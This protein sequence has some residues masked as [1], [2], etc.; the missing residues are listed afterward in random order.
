MHHRRDNIANKEM[1]T[2][3][4][5][6]PCMKL[7]LVQTNARWWVHVVDT[8]AKARPRQTLLPHLSQWTGNR[9]CSKQRYKDAIK[10]NLKNYE[11]Q[12]RRGLPCINPCQQS[13]MQLALTLRKVFCWMFPGTVVLTQFA[14]PAPP[15]HSCV[16]DVNSSCNW[17]LS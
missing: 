3:R 16:L 6:I 12:T 10:Q 2:D 17:S 11:M 5:N 4:A 7:L 8:D 14:A 1:S 9:T 15:V 13:Q